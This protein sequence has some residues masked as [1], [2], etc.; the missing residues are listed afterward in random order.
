[1]GPVSTG[2]AVALLGVGGVVV[3]VAV[4]AAALT[5]GDR[6]AGRLTGWLFGVGLTMCLVGGTGL[7]VRHSE[8]RD[9]VD[10]LHTA[11]RQIIDDAL[12]S[13]RNCA[14]A[15]PQP[16]IVYPSGLLPGGGE[17]T[18]SPPACSTSP[19]GAWLDSSKGVY[20]V[21]KA[22]SFSTSGQVT[23]TDPE[24]GKQVCAVI[25]DTADSPGAVTDGPCGG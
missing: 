10:G 23:V 7:L 12:D 11:G 3:V 9:T 13:A 4:T 8:D 19:R 1:M 18:Y 6:G 22:D 15:A 5:R 2:P 25:P 24:S 20:Q 14:T 17:A 21:K 16:T